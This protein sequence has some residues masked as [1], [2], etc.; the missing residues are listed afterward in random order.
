MSKKQ[1]T[2]SVFIREDETNRDFHREVKHYQNEFKSNNGAN[3][4]K[5]RAIVNMVLSLRRKR[6]EK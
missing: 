4:S 2:T 6:L 1:E 5:G 3:I